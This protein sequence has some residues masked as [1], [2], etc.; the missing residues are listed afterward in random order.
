MELKDIEQKLSGMQT[1]TAKSI[2]DLAAALKQRQDEFEAKGSIDP[3]TKDKIGRLFTRMDQLEAAANKP[4]APSNGNQAKSIG[5]LATESAEFTGALKNAWR[6]A[7]GKVAIPVNASIPSLKTVITTGGIGTQTTGVQ[8]LQRLPGLTGLPKQALRIR[9]LLKVTPIST[10]SFD[11]VKQATR[12]NAASPQIESTTKAES[13]YTWTSASGTVKTI[14]HFTNVSRQ[15]L[16]DVKWLRSEIDGEL[17][18]GLKLK[19]E[20]EILAGDG[21]G[22][23]LSGLITQATAYAG[24]Y[25]VAS[26]T[27]VDRLRW[28]LLEARLAGLNTFGPDG[29]VLHP[30]DMA[31]IEHIKDEYGG[32]ANTGKY[33]IGDPIS[34]TM[35]KTLWGMPVVE[36]D[37]ISVGQFLVGAFASGAE[38]VDRMQATVLIS[39]EHGT[40]FTDNNATILCEERIGL[41]VRRPGAFIQGT[42]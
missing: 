22:Q 14:A 31:R 26:D 38:L 12:V 25:N 34:G 37:S 6:V 32:A 21:L 33:I 30:V 16:D 17:M 29:F 20:S 24:T 41:A 8:E 36:S 19:E 42:F 2:A 18:Y 27:R 13:T 1:E 39:F 10:N 9:D 35:V 4:A 3:E 7:H 40:N 11:Y 23:H 28:A 5:D 15:A